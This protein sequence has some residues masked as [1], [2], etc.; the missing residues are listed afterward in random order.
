MIGALQLVDML[1]AKIPAQYK[2]A[3][4][5]EGVFHE[6]DVL[7][8]REISS[9]K[10]KD[11]D[12]DKESPEAPDSGSPPVIPP[13][14]TSA[15]TIPGFKKLSSLSLEPD[16]A[17]TLRSRVI[18]FKYLTDHEPETD[19]TFEILHRLVEQLSVPDASEKELSN[20]LTALAGLFTSPH[21]SVSS[22]EL[23][24]SGLVD[25]LLLFAVDSVRTGENKNI[26][27][28]YTTSFHVVI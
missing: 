8:S 9:S 7:A 16:D 17:V 27:L 13:S 3:F 10:P 28:N 15:A 11:K 12:K 18:R 23:L 22:F 5:R 25:G 2:P 26:L 14:S 1:L 6:I 24:Q 4:R 20:V 19:N 21:T